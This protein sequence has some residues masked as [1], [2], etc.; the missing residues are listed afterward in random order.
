MLPD[1]LLRRDDLALLLV[2]ALGFDCFRA[3]LGTELKFVGSFSVWSLF[4][5]PGFKI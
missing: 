1:W 2:C 5:L 3:T 4:A